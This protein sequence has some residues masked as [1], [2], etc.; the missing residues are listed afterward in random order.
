LSAVVANHSLA[1]AF[2]AAARALGSVLAGQSLTDAL[3][4]LKRR[5]RVATLAA[6]AQDLCYNAMRGYGVIDVALDRLLQKPLTDVPL[7]GLLLAA[8]A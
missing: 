3:G 6:A 2:A 4:E 8:L 7:R 5:V 1:E